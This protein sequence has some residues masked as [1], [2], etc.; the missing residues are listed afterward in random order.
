MQRQRLFLMVLFL[1]SGCDGD[2]PSAKTAS[3]W[4]EQ[5]RQVRS[6]K[7]KSI[8][9]TNEVVT[10]EQWQ[11]LADGVA[12]LETLDVERLEIDDGSYEILPHLP[13]LRQVRIGSEV[14]DAALEHL[15]NVA[16][17]H[18]MNLPQGTFTD[19]GLRSLSTLPQLELLR[20]HSPHV[21]D[22]GLSHIAR[23]PSLRFLHLIR[24]PIT[25]AGLK[26]L[27]G[28]DQLESLYLDGCDCTDDG[29]LQ[30][31]EALPDLH[32]HRDQLHL[33]DDPH[34]HEH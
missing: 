7:Q 6:G 12:S 31:L 30:L 23:L 15:S 18:V 17:L 21:T 34:A 19:E 22:D 1:V 10:N 33:E 26:H 24:V 8:R 13:L 32:L 28:L 4:E 5:L 20:F 9:V 27:E 3:Q 2:A 11:G 16:P 29:I 25:D 14:D